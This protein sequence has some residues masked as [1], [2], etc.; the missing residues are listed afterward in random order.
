VLLDR[1]HQGFRQL[2]VL[3]QLERFTQSG[4]RDFSEAIKQRPAAD[5]AD[6]DWVRRAA[7]HIKALQQGQ[8]M[9]LPVKNVT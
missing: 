7:F 8:Q 1:K 3:G 4:L 9:Q 2:H 6:A 5:V